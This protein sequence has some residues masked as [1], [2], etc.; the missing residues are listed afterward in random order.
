V[1]IQLTSEAKAGVAATNG[2]STAIALELSTFILSFA[3]FSPVGRATTTKAVNHDEKNLFTTVTIGD[4]CS[5]QCKAQSNNNKGVFAEHFLR[6][7][8]VMSNNNA[9]EAIQSG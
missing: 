2:A 5:G 3:S 9:I 8:A 4:K 7:I 6:V 1:Q